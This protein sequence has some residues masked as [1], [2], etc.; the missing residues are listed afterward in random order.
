MTF[1]L[2]G[3]RDQITRARLATYALGGLLCLIG[4]VVLG[5]AVVI[6]PD[7]RTLV[8]RLIVSVL[9]VLL[10][11][12]LTVANLN[13]RRLV[14]ESSRLQELLT[15]LTEARRQVLRDEDPRQVVVQAV[16][17]V[18]RAR[19]SVLVEP[20]DGVLRV[21]ATAGTA[22]PDLRIPLDEPS[23]VGRVFGSSQPLRV[24]DIH[25]EEDGAQSV[26]RAMEQLLGSRLHSIAY[27]PV[28]AHGSPQGV[29]CAAFDE[30]NERVAD[31]AVPPLELLAAE[32]AIT[33]EREQILEELHT[34]ALTDVLTGIANRRA[35]QASMQSLPRQGGMLLLD[36]D[37]FKRVNDTWGHDAGDDVLRAFAGVLRDTVRDEDLCA[38]VGGEEFA[39]LFPD[40]DDPSSLVARIRTSWEAVMTGLELGTVTFS[41]GAAVREPHESVSDLQRRCDRALYAAKQDGRDRLVFASAL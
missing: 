24:R 38:R 16:L 15:T 20:F 12:G 7:S 40:G 27:V 3:T 34:L 17:D 23:V 19:V 37:H 10:W 28:R 9:W 32:L 2:A 26:L 33:L 18:T 41:A 11:I 30:V 36:L 6:A 21:T 31:A 13:A 14:S 35:W 8:L 1:S 29:L 39:I 5:I 25:D 22:L 4:T